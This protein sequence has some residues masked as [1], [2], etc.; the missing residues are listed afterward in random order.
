M[1]LDSKPFC[2]GCGAW[3]ENFDEMNVS[4]FQYCE[5]CT[6]KQPAKV[7]VSKKG[8]KVTKVPVF[9]LLDISNS[10]FFGF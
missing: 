1:E 3:I 5:W 2:L 9:R 4:P 10:D 6:P 8:Q 7:K